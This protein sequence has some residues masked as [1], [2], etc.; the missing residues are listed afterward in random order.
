MGIEAVKN[1]PDQSIHAVFVDGCHFYSCVEEDLRLW[2]PKIVPGGLIL[3]HDF[4]P[5][6]PGV[7]RAVWEMRP[8]KKVFLA[9]DWMYWWQVDEDDVN[10]LEKNYQEK[11]ALEGGNAYNS[12]T[13]SG[14]EAQA[15]QEL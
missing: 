14:D 2:M 13:N 7:V 9:M 5:Q 11:L 12:S 6:W 10:Y 8:N 1:V 3:G 15:E 4:S